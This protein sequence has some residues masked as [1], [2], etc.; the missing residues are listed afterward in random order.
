MGAWPG[1][2]GLLLRS[3]LTQQVGDRVMV[4]RDG[5]R[6]QKPLRTSRRIAFSRNDYT[7]YVVDVIDSHFRDVIILLCWCAGVRYL[8]RIGDEVIKES[9]PEA[10]RRRRR[11]NLWVPS[12][13]RKTKDGSNPARGVV[14]RGEMTIASSRTCWDDLGES[15]VAR[16]TD[17]LVVSRP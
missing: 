10:A 9:Q 14:L 15:S 17:L 3:V 2:A 5:R 7:E 12:H 6:V 4:A 1:L 16:V 13:V 11:L 8:R